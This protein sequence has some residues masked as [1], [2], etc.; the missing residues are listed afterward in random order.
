MPSITEN[1]GNVVVE[2]LAQGTPV[3]ASKGTPWQILE[4]TNAGYWIEVDVESIKNCIDTVISLNDYEYQK[5]RKN[6][7]ATVDN[8]FNIEKNIVNWDRQF[9]LISN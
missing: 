6:A 8:H 2:S 5:M 9:Q 4:E 7:F 3:I 1:F